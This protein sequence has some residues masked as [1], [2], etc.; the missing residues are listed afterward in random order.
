MP[1]TEFKIGDIVIYNGISY[2]QIKKGRKCEIIAD[3]ETPYNMLLT[4]D[5]YAGKGQDF[6]L[7]Q[8]FTEDDQKA[9]VTFLPFVSASKHDLLPST[10]N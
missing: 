4:G 3:K 8:F 7:A 6:L 5:I 9:K 2:S 1:E 10:S